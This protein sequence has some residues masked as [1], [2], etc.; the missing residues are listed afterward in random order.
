[1]SSK[2]SKYERRIRSAKL[3]ARSELGDSPHSWYSCK[4]ADNFNLSLSTVRDCCPRID[5]CKVAYEEFVAEYEHP[6]QPVV[7]HNAQ[8]DWKAGENWTLKLLDKKYHN[9]RFKCGEDDKGCPVKLKMKY[10]IRYMK[11]NEDDSPLYIFD[12]NYGE[13]SRRKKL[14]ND[15]MICRYFKEDLF[16]LGG[17][18][19]R[20]PYRWFVMGPPRSGTSIH[21]DPLGTS[22]WN[23]L[24]RGYKRWCLFPPRTPKE[25]VKPKPSD[26]GK[27]RN[28]AISWFVYVYPRTQ[29]SDWPT[30]Y[31]PIE[32]LQCPG[33]TVFVPGG[34][35]HVV[36]NLTNT[37]AVTQNFCS[38][39]NFPIVWHKTARK[40]PKFAKRWL[41]ALRI[42]RPDLAKIADN[43]NLSEHFPDVPSSS[44]S[45]CSSSSSRSSSYCSTCTSTNQSPE[46]MRQ[47]NTRS[48]LHSV[49]RSPTPKRRR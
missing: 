37:I 1:M 23:A 3:K 48:G 42:N 6:Y 28:E 24:V 2:H 16:S 25:L 8:T 7:I 21:I 10:F 40:R 11:E 26:G 49:S 19:T 12:A 36:L 29:A 46:K 47:S 14:L 13:H 39:T 4:Y 20:P 31:A 45:S 44:S 33:E 32:I 34:W 30:E 38:S 27:N 35:W 5:A 22:A 9:E 15:Y 17:E 43:I 41:A 18:K